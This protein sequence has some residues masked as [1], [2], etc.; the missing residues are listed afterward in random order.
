MGYSAISQVAPDYSSSSSRQPNTSVQPPVLTHQSF[1][2]LSIDFGD[3]VKHSSDGHDVVA[4]TTSTSLGGASTTSF[5]LPEAANEKFDDPAALTHN[6][7]LAW[8]DATATSGPSSPLTNSNTET[9][10]V[11]PPIRTPLRHVNSAPLCH[12]TPDLQSLQGA[13]TGNVERL[14]KS[15]ERFSTEFEISD[16][17]QNV[18]VG[19]QSSSRPRGISFDLKL[20]SPRST[21]S[22]PRFYSP[23]NLTSI[24]IYSS[25]TRARV[26]AA[27]SA[28]RLPYISE[29]ENENSGTDLRGGQAP[30]NLAAIPQIIPFPETQSSSF[31]PSAADSSKSTPETAPPGRSTSAG[32]A[33]TYRQAT[34]LFKDFDGVHFTP[35]TNESLHPRR[36]SLAKPPLAA[37]PDHF[38]EPAP[39]QNMVYYPAPVPMVLNLPQRL[40]QKPPA[41]DE[42]EKRRSQLLMGLPHPAARQSALWTVEAENERVERENK[43]KPN[44]APQLRASAFFE[45]PKAHLD[46][47]VQEN[48]AVATLDSILDAAAHAPVS[49]F[50]DHPIVG[51]VGAEVYGRSK[52]KKK[53]KSAK[54]SSTIP[55]LSEDISLVP[56]SRSDFAEEHLD[57][58]DER[59]PFQK[60]HDETH[61]SNEDG[62]VPTNGRRKDI[63]A[64]RES[65]SDDDGSEE[66]NAVEE[67]YI[68]PPTTLLAELQMRKQE[69]KQRNRTAATSFPN[70]MHSTLLELDTIA[71]RQRDKRNKGHVTLA[72][73]D[74]EV[75][76][77]G[78][79]DDEDVPLGVLFPEKNKHADENR[80]LGLMEKLQLE[81]NEPLSHRRARIRGEVLNSPMTRAL[82]RAAD[83]AKRSSNAYTLAIPGIVE[84]E[85][86]EDDQ[87]PLAQ[88]LKRLKS[89]E[90]GSQD[91]FAT[92]LLSKFGDQPDQSRVNNDS[93][94]V[95]EEEGET[96]AQR[97]KR[98]QTESRNK[99]LPTRRS[100][101]DI[102]KA[103]PIRPGSQPG[104]IASPYYPSTLSRGLANPGH[105]GNLLVSPIRPAGR[106]LESH[107]TPIDPNQ[108]D[109]IDRWR[110]SVQQ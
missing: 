39:G 40:S 61:S 55:A 106:G 24:P 87:E 35:H 64:H 73:E 100:M 52:L 103:H 77:A 74:P 46:I 67:T 3:Q 85:S 17:L 79:S 47:C 110:L 22:S 25:N 32:S 59:T 18:P 91:D 5:H 20:G 9:T 15:A 95:Q 4:S 83:L 108:R 104:Q 84:N 78:K 71:Q 105:N 80:P 51:H 27:S 96:L 58:E 11:E 94:E 34:N 97:R 92:G 69:Q 23:G 38:S 16:G 45:P 102:L 7:P 14:E 88:R 8:I 37:K 90:E 54:R 99:A 57:S 109:M 82:P 93:G 2:P 36:L 28:S 76:E 56:A 65:N 48:S 41:V 30:F 62:H 107:I 21:P 81:E 10:T 53:G 101:A 29:P 50:T 1:E 89:R 42:Q 66:S 33:D 26:R 6:L 44:L 98:L 70:G 68:G 86:E 19:E 72:W 75:V 43:R 63:A 49:A 13:Y 12:P 31:H 60:S